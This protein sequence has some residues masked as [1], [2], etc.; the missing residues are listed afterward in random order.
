MALYIEAK[1]EGGAGFD[2]VF[3]EARHLQRIVDLKVCFRFS[4]AWV[5][6]G[7]NTTRETAWEQV[8][9]SWA[10]DAYEIYYD[11]CKQDGTERVS[12]DLWLEERKMLIN[13]RERMRIMKGVA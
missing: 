13:E 10:R 4:G 12:F 3:R 2:D 5:C 11:K 7:V 1:V 6:V 8:E 9:E